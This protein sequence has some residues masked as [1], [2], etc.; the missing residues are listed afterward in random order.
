MRARLRAAAYRAG[1]S[2]YVAASRPGKILR[3][4]TPLETPSGRSMARVQVDR[5]DSRGY[6]VVSLQPSNGVKAGTRLGVYFH[7]GSYVHG[8]SRFHWALLADIVRRSGARVLVSGYPLADRQKADRTVPQAAD[9]VAEATAL[10]GPNRTV[11]MGDSAG[12]GLALASLQALQASGRSQPGH[13]I[14]LAPWLDLSLSDPSQPSVQVHDP[15]LRIR[16]LARNARAYAGDLDLKD[17]RVSPLFGPLGALAPL[18]VFCGGDDIAVVDSRRLHDRVRAVGGDIQYREEPGMTHFYSMGP[19][20][21]PQT[22]RVR[23]VLV[24]ALAAGNH[25]GGFTAVSA[26]GSSS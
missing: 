21:L 25:R 3:A 10:A 9:L 20:I 2:A 1:V 17:P 5:D 13:A 7:G 22:Q 12:G 15:V 18:T 19:A 4:S 6:P 24:T 11:V 23:R 8:I 16:D 26:G 14:L